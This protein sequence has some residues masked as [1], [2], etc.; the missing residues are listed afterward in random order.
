MY[1][2]YLMRVSATLIILAVLFIIKHWI[3]RQHH[4]NGDFQYL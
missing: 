1:F 3:A 2:D 4:F